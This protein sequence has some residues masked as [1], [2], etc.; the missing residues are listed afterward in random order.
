MVASQENEGTKAGETG[1]LSRH[2]T[3]FAVG[4][5]LAAAFGSSFIP[6]TAIEG[7]VTA[8]GIAELLPAA[9]PPLGDTARLALSGGIGTLTAGALLALLPRA[10]TEDM[11]FETTVKKAGSAGSKVVNSDTATGK[12]G[13]LAGWLRT[14]RFGKSEPAAGTV[15][16]FADINRLRI[17]N[18]DQH[19]DAP[20]RSPILAS[21]DLGEPDVPPSPMAADQNAP[22]PL[23]LGEDMAFGA[24]VPASDEQDVPAAQAPSFRFAPPPILEVE[25]EIE[26]EVEIEAGAEPGFARDTPLWPETLADRAAAP[27]FADSAEEPARPVEHAFSASGIGSATH[28]AEVPD[29]EDEEDLEALNVAELLARLE[30]GLAR[31]RQGGQEPFTSGSALPET[32]ARLFSLAKAPSL[33]GDASVDEQPAGAEPRPL[34]FRL[35]QPAAMQGDDTLQPLPE[36]GSDAITPPADRLWTSA[37]EYQPPV[38]GGLEAEALPMT[39]D[40]AS[41]KVGAAVPETTAGSEQPVDDDMDA[42]LRDALSTL[43][44]LSDR[45]RNS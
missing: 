28:A 21:S 27:E 14:L 42:A 23:E 13:K 26:T 32:T 5:G 18:G 16:D 39:D 45:Q 40:G 22:M 12:G 33:A 37:V 1:V 36:T 10:E 15:T 9:A 19:P 11:G 20:M 3:A 6:M 35:G 7:F 43:R 34:R 30:A 2:P 4:G 29:H 17:R 8:Y 25:A 31:R 24:P 44:Q 38:V 41:S